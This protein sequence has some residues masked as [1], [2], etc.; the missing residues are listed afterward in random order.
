MGLE[1]RFIASFHFNALQE[2]VWKTMNPRQLD[3][4][5]NLNTDHMCISNQP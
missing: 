2:L 1:L 3:N 4:V 5:D